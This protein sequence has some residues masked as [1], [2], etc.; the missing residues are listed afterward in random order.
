VVYERLSEHCDGFCDICTAAE[1]NLCFEPA[2]RTEEQYML[3]VCV[4]FLVCFPNV[5]V[6]RKLL[7]C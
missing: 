1:D 6:P 7:P 4:G 5:I 2:A 3:R